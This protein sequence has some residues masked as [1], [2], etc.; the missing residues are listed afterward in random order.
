MSVLSF[1]HQVEELLEILGQIGELVGVIVPLVEK[2]ELAQL[3]VNHAKEMVKVQLITSFLDQLILLCRTLS[4]SRSCGKRVTNLM[5]NFQK[6]RLLLVPCMSQLQQLFNQ[7][8]FPPTTTV[9]VIVS[10]QLK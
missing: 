4:F 2:Q 10:F 6:W 8:Y 3:I 9:T 7:F 1:I 5:I